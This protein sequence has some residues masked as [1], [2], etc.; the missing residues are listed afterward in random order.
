LGGLDKAV[1]MLRQAQHDK[2]GG[3]LIRQNADFQ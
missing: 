3:R 2:R 1:E